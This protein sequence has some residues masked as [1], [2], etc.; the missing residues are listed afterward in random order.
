MRAP[1][2]DAC[3]ILC[4]DYGQ[5]ICLH[6]VV[7]QMVVQVVNAVLLALKPKN[8]TGAH[9]HKRLDFESPMKLRAFE[10]QS[11]PCCLK[12]SQGVVS[13]IEAKSWKH[14]RCAA[15]GRYEEGT[16]VTSEASQTSHEPGL[17]RHV[18]H[19]FQRCHRVK[20]MPC[21][22]RE[23]MLSEDTCLVAAELL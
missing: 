16:P 11:M 19:D 6:Q 13:D 7:T 17:I 5:G 23:S 9:K 18:L 2:Q 20:L 8:A 4:G 22:W 3:N 12:A 10:A 14:L 1:R 15:E 21:K